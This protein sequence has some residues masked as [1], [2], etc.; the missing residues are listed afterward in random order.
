MK[1]FLLALTITA[2]WLPSI[3]QVKQTPISS[4]VVA[5]DSVYICDSKTAYAYHLKQDCS[6]LNKCTHGIFKISKEDAVKLYGRKACER[7]K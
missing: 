6:G 1:Q 7:C 4:T 5:A 3:S 2:L